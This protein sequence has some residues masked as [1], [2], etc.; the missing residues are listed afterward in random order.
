MTSCCEA[1]AATRC[2]AAP[3]GPSARRR[4]D[5]RIAAAPLYTFTY[6]LNLI[7]LETRATDLGERHPLFRTREISCSSSPPPSAAISPTSSC[8]TSTTRSV[9][10]RDKEVSLVE[11]G[12]RGA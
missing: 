4:R 9:D 8:C 1:A 3:A 12:V 11:V 2:W 7:A 6:S 10:T 5:D